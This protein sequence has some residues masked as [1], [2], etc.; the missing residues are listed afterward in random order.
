MRLPGHANPWRV[1]AGPAAVYVLTARRMG[2]L[3][4][5]HQLVRVHTGLVL[6]MVRIAP[7]ALIPLAEEAT[8]WAS[9]RQDTACKETGTPGFVVFWE[10]LKPLPPDRSNWLRSK[11]RGGHSNPRQPMNDPTLQKSAKRSYTQC[12]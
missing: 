12:M 4:L 6:D 11:G 10:A 7:L 9:D 3:P 8:R 5:S 2:W 1:A